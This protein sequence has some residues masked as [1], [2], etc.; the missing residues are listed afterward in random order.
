MDPLL[1][2]YPFWPY[3]NRPPAPMFIGVDLAQ[4]DDWTALVI[5]ERT[6]DEPNVYQTRYLER[7]RPKRYGEVIHRLAEVISDLRTPTNTY[8]FATGRY[9][10]I[11]PSITG[12]VDRSG[13]GRAVGDAFEDA[14]LPWDLHLVTITGGDVATK[15]GRYHRVPKRDLASSIAVLLQSERLQITPDLPES[16]HLKSELLNFK[17]KYTKRGHDTYS[18]GKAS[19]VDWRDDA[20]THDDLVL[21]Q[22]LSL[23]YAETY[24][25][26]GGF[27]QLPQATTAALEGW[28]A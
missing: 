13:V 11:R 12:V 23:W 9:E 8:N 22:A 4:A 5:N 6:A 17:I 25:D 20:N 28:F 7:W 27:S 18:A 1:L 26:T 14:D 15:D 16:P 3:E 10:S 19:D 24:G 21:A 2:E